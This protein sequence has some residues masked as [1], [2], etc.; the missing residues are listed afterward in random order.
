MSMEKQDITILNDDFVR[1]SRSISAAYLDGQLTLDEMWVL[2][3]LWINAN[4]R[5]GRTM[6]SYEALSKD[7]KGRYSKNVMNKIMLGLKRK[8]LVGFHKQQGR[9]SSF[10]VDIQNYPL[11]TG[12]F[13]D[14]HKGAKSN[15][16]RSS[17]TNIPSNKV[18]IP[19]E[20]NADWQKLETEK[21]GLAE[22]L[23]MDSG[24]DLGRSSN[25]DNEKDNENEVSV[26]YKKEDNETINDFFPKS[27]EEERCLKIASALEEKNIKY[28][29]SAL[30]KYGLRTLEDAFNEMQKRPADSI[31]NKGAYFNTIVKRIAEKNTPS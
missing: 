28:I 18:A 3:W 19:A 22:G 8:K 24:N 23:S 26:P 25:N 10:Y 29:L 5:T 21:K 16:G 27:Y 20:V 4:P 12:G 9:R 17:D 11:S 15:S 31:K 6:T 14:I 2:I 7:F 13:K 30:R 1:L